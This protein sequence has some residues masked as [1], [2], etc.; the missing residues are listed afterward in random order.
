MEPRVTSELLVSALRRHAES[1]GGF[2]T[3]LARGDAVAGAILVI[4]AE[5]G[6]NTRI[7]ERVLGPK[8]AYQWHKVA[9]QAAQNE[10]ESQKF[11]DRRRKNDPDLWLIE[12]DVPSAERFTAEM[13]ESV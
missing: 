10:V 8:G 12:L 5:R 4:L 3:I 7:L 13:N 1:G 9:G 2:A 11:L 6:T